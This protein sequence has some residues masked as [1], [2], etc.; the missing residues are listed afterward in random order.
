MKD[1]SNYWLPGSP[2]GG[3]SN[4]AYTGWQP[5]ASNLNAYLAPLILSRVKQ[6]PRTWKEAL[7][8]AEIPLPLLSYRVKMI[9]MFVDCIN[10]G[11]VWSCIERRKDMVLLKDYCIC[12]E[13]GNEDEAATKLIKQG[14]YKEIMSHCLDSIFYGYTLLGI[15]GIK[16]GVPEK[17]TLVRRQNISPDRLNIAPVPYSPGGIE[18]LNP[19]EKDDS[20]NRFIDWTIWVPTP[21]DIGMS[22]CGY[23]LL[24]KIALYQILC[25]NNLGDNATYN[26]LFGQPLRL[27]K[28]D[29]TDAESRAKLAQTLEDMGSTA[30][31]ILSKEDDLDLLETK[32]GAGSANGPYDNLEQRLEKK[33]SKLILGHSDAL[34]STSGKLGSTGKDDDGAGKAVADKEKKDTDFMEQVMNDFVN[35]KLMNLGVKIPVGK[36]FRFKNDKEKQEIADKKAASNK[37]MVDIVK[38]L[39]DAGLKVDPRFITESTG[40]P[41]EAAPEPAPNTLVNPNIPKDIKNKMEAYYGVK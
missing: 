19:T 6:D 4:S 3:R 32:N 38:T 33:I 22:D 29:K 14:W 31:A 39:A 15:G 37:V 30:Y 25:R 9:Q 5:S 27:G 12:D 17:I 20:G 8:E 11:H 36:R 13:D 28:T 16:D 1:I 40:I 24:Y 2:L 35:P 34:D 10:D 23:G 7:Q 18:F 41:V 21:S 26:E